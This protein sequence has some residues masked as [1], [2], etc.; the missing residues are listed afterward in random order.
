M[1]YLSCIV[2]FQ[3]LSSCVKAMH[4]EPDSVS[5]VNK[6]ARG[7]TLLAADMHDLYTV[8]YLSLLIMP[9]PPRL[10]VG[11]DFE[12]GGVDP[13][14]MPFGRGICLIWGIFAAQSHVCV[15]LI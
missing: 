13:T 1:V 2:T 7:L 10:V 6:S 12:G 9:H 4:D 3:R 5:R 11:G 14:S 15:I 8:M